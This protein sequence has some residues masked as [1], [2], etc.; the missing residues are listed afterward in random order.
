M[1]NSNNKPTAVKEKNVTVKGLDT[2]KTLMGN[3]CPMLSTDEVVS[4]VSNPKWTLETAKALITVAEMYGNTVKSELTPELLSAYIEWVILNRVNYVQNGRNA[5][6]PKNV[7][8]PVVIY[9]A[10]AKMGRFEGVTTI[11]AN[12]LP[13]VGEEQPMS[14][15]SQRAVYQW[16]NGLSDKE[17]EEISVFTPIDWVKDGKIV[18][19]PKLVEFERLMSVAGIE[20]AT[21]VPMNRSVQDDNMF[22]MDVKTEGEITTAGNAPDISTVFARCFYQF[23][24]VSTLFGRQKVELMLYKAMESALFDVMKGYVKNFRA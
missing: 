3:G 12:I 16:E 4:V 1:S 11:G 24:A 22:K 19:F 20:L 9:D 17:M 6:H 7:K 23:D 13:N 2:L 15:L 21:G 18:E 14:E 10:L 5:I 8:Y